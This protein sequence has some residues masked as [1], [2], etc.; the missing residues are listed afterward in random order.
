MLA[1]ARLRCLDIVCTASGGGGYRWIAREFVAG[2][3][4]AVD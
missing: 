3:V 1:W 4:V 2:T